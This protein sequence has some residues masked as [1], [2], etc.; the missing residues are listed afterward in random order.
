MC[1]KM[2]TEVQ[3][4]NKRIAKNTLLLY[5]RMLFLMGV[6]LYISRVIL[7][8]LGVVD[9]GIY[10]IVGG[11]VSLF[12]LISTSLSS[13]ISRFIT[14]ELGT[15]NKGRLQN[16]FSSSINIQIILGG[17]ILL[18]AETIGLWFLNNKL[19]ILDNRLVAANWVYQFSL[20]TFLLNLVS[21]PFN[22]TIIA[23]EKMSAFAYISIIEAVSRLIIS[24]LIAFSPIDRLIFFSLG[25]TIISVIIRQLYVWYCRTHFDECKYSF[26][27]DKGLLKEMFGF[28][29]WNFIGAASSILRDQGGNVI[30]NLFFGSTVNAARGIA[31]QVNAAIIGFVNSFMT[32]LNPQ[33][34]KSYASGNND[35]LMLLIFQGARF[36]FYMILLLSLPVILNAQYILELWL[37]VVPEHTSTFVQLILVFA[38]FESISNPLITAMLATGKI[39]NYQ[40][41]VGGFQILNL[42]ISYILLRIGYMPESVFAV[43]IVIGQIC[44]LARL[45]MLKSMIGLNFFAY[46]KKVFLN[47]L[48]VAIVASVLP[49]YVSRVLDNSIQS[50]LLI[51]LLAIL[52]S[53]ISIIYVGFDKRERKEYSMKIYNNI[54]SRIN[55]K[56]R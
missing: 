6:N 20:L 23:H 27:V 2:S 1:V 31:N 55:D 44:L 12:S 9:Y 11:V 10:N 37:N 50:F 25:L 14:F 33:I 7:N 3:S 5:L 40:I 29:G 52:C 13:A 43:A 8:A 47:I 48:A 49:L 51:S 4:N 28:A 41:I 38:M 21:V 46:I 36:S 53:A 19:V 30:L 56:N 18:L 16:I 26:S 39:R 35:Y 42:P 24:F 45:L 22:A 54:V 32:A 15:N 17:G 34:T